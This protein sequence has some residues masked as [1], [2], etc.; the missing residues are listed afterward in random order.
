MDLSTSR[1]PGFYQLKLQERLDKLEEVLH[2]S[3][4]D[5]AALSGLAGLDANKADHMV[6]NAIGIHALPLGLGL[7]FLIN[8]REVLVP[9]AIEEPSVI[10]GASFMAKLAR[11]GGGFRAHTSP[12]EMIA[13]IQVLEL[14]HHRISPVG[15]PGEKTG[16]IGSNR[17]HRSH[18]D[19][20]GRWTA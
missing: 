17:Q 11:A 10:A 9:M 6:E 18:S 16:F 2:L 19:K 12:P 5:L 3:A 1:I 4:D 15:Y 8:D 7:N 20:P 13:Q 14:A